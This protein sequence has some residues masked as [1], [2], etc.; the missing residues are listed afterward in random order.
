MMSNWQ[1]NWQIIM[2]VANVNVTVKME[3]M[4]NWW[5]LLVLWSTVRCFAV[6]IMKNA[7][8]KVNLLSNKMSSWNQWFSNQNMIVMCKMMNHKLQIG[9]LNKMQWILNI[10]KVKANHSRNYTCEG[11]LL[12]KTFTNQLIVD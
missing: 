11:M 6:W 3:L 12:A 8:F 5:K 2:L 7:L 1:F 9:S 4:M 10:K